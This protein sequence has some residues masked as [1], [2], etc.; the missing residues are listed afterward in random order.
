MLIIEGTRQGL[1]IITYYLITITHTQYEFHGYDRLK[2]T[3]VVL[4]EWNISST[5]ARICMCVHSIMEFLQ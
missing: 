1:T 3:I 2:E 5:Y 4:Q